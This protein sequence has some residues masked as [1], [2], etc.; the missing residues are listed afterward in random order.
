MC[1]LDNPLGRD[2][3]ILLP[4]TYCLET[5]FNC[6]VQYYFL[7]DMF[8]I[9]LKN[10]DIIL[11]PNTRGHNV[12][13]EISKY[14]AENGITVLAL[15][16]EGNIRTDAEYDYWG[17]NKDRV[18]Y[19]EY[20]T[21]W[22]YRVKEYLIKK[23]IG[24][25]DKLVVTGGTF[26]DRYIFEKG[27]SKEDFLKRKGLS[28]YKKVVGYAGWAFGKMFG[29]EKKTAFTHINSNY[30]IANEW[31]NEQREMVRESLRQL[32]IHNPDILFLLK[33]H[34]KESYED[35]IIELPNEMNELLHYE[36]VKYFKNEEDIMTLISVSDIWMGFETTTLME[37]WILNKPTVLINKQIDFPRA[38]L[39]KGSLIK[40]RP[41]DIQQY[42][43][44]YYNTGKINSFYE[45]VLEK[46]REDLVSDSIGFKDGLNHIRVIYYFLDKIKAKETNSKPFLNLRHLRLYLLMHIGRFFY[47][48]SIF[49]TLPKFKKTIYVFENRK[50]PGFIER[51]TTLYHSISKFHR[52]NDIDIL[53][54]SL[55]TKKLKDFLLNK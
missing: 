5:Y 11:L 29:R 15:E 28:S 34:P 41:D 13:F 19:Q 38:D 20:L 21:C 31:V 23:N 17:Y 48:K 16:S 27:E 18:L 14:G 6:E 55:N 25:P 9:R 1:F 3:E 10:P 37:A 53:I 39:Y 33:K 51:K 40:W 22:S 30:K 44:E 35:D 4:V 49:E 36:N 32:I 2:T 24:H 42:I 7:W 26:F 47:S 52:S 12:Y 50:L 43:N 54:P 46:E 8:Q 45:T